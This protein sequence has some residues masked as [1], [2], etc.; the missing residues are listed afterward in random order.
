MAR[1]STAL[2]GRGFQMGGPAGN[3]RKELPTPNDEA[4]AARV[5]LELLAT[6]LETW[7]VPF[8]QTSGV[9]YVSRA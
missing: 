9:H 4:D 2:Q 1:Q 3:F 8:S 7:L 5:V 6:G